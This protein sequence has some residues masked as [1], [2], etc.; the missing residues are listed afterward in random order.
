MSKY[1]IIHAD[2]V[3][4][5][6]RIYCESRLLLDSKMAGEPCINV[7]HCTVPRGGCTA[8]RGKDGKLSGGKHE[9]SEIYMCVSGHG[10]LWLDD[11]KVDFTP[12]TLVYI[13]GGVEHYVK[14]LS[15]TETVCFLT[16]WPNEQD[17]ET[18]HQRKA[19]WGEGYETRKMLKE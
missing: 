6:G 14:N 5:Y 12:G 19:A 9:K 7:N 3:L 11:E 18:W 16:F 8:I 15:E 10:D 2:E 1:L 17:N 13:R 4:N